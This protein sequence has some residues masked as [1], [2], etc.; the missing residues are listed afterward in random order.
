M[1]KALLQRNIT[2]RHYLHGQFTSTVNANVRNNGKKWKNIF[3]KW[4]KKSMNLN[5][6]DNNNKAIDE[7]KFR[8]KHSFYVLVF[9]LD[10]IETFIFLKKEFFGTAYYYDKNESDKNNKYIDKKN[11]TNLPE[12]RYECATL[13]HT[14]KN[15]KSI[16]TCSSYL[17]FVAP[18]SV[19]IVVATCFFLVWQLQKFNSNK[20]IK[21]IYQRC[22]WLFFFCSD[23]TFS[24]LLPSSHPA[25]SK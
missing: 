15:A 19:A 21:I 6:S 16:R 3:E 2:K 10:S 23:A 4:W 24:V 5:N 18:L 11:L 7:R 9:H 1:K 12:L 8:T 17:V 22:L 20:K 14:N 13:V 25:H